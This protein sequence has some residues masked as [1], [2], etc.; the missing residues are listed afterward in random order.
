LKLVIKK[1]DIT[2][3]V[4]D[5]SIN[6]LYQIIDR[7]LSHKEVT[8]EAKSEEVKKSKEEVKEVQIVRIPTT[9]ESVK[10]NLE[11]KIIR[12]GNITIDLVRN[13]L[14]Y[15]GN[16]YNLDYIMSILQLFDEGLSPEEISKKL[17]R[18]KFTVRNYELIRRKLIESGVYNML[19]TR[20]LY[21]LS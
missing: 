13:K 20:I 15:A 5:I 2:I 17:G 3:E 21:Q 12:V 8:I 4:H 19:K 7:I 9:T 18:S 14:T 11:D 1:K 16:T 6:E 10:K